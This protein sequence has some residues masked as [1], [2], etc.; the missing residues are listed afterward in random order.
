MG[1]T[2]QSER[3]REAGNACLTYFST[4][5]SLYVQA[6]EYCTETAA[7]PPPQINTG[8]IKMA[9][10]APSMKKRMYEVLLDAWVEDLPLPPGLTQIYPPPSCGAG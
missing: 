4:N 1:W 8:I 6:M 5:L 7:E 3:T 2:K 9:D 10:K